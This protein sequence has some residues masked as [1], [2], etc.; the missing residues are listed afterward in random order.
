M[1]HYLFTHVDDEGH[2]CLEDEAGKSICLPLEWLPEGAAPG[3]TFAVL[4][5]ANGE[6]SRVAFEISRGSRDA[7]DRMN[8]GG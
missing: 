3:A 7:P 6:G 1:P 5:V 4:V 2:A 8:V